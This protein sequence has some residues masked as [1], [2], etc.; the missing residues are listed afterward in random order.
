LVGTIGLAP[1]VRPSTVEV[2]TEPRAETIVLVLYLGVL[3]TLLGYIL[4]N[5]GL[6][7]LG[8]TRAVTYAYGIP[9]LAV[10]I[11]AVAL[12]E[13]VTVWLVVGGALVVGGIVIAQRGLPRRGLRLRASRG[14][15]S[16]AES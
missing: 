1:L 11:G 10:A 12:D 4:W 5:E 8:P 14:A 7:G 6:R 15:P 9:P 3:A 2:V 16:C 13:P